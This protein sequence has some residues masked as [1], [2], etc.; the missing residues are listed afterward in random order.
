MYRILAAADQIAASEH[1][2]VA[3]LRSPAGTAVVFCLGVFCFAWGMG[4]GGAVVDGLIADRTRAKKRKKDTERTD[5]C[6]A[7]RY[8]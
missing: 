2:F 8:R 1:W 7:Y 4:F 5:R 3:C 6:N